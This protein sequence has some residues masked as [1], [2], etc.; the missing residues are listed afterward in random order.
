MRAAIVFDCVF[1]ATSGG[2]ERVYT[3]IADELVA[4]GVTVDYLTRELDA[5]ADAGF[6][7][8]PVWDGEIYDSGGNRTTASALRFALG[9]FR[10]LR[11]HR[12]D[13]DIVIGSTLPALTILAARV[14]LVGSRTFLVADWLEVWPWRKWRSYAGV[15]TGTLGFALQ[16]VS[17]R[18]GD[19]HTVNSLFTAGRL[20]RYRRTPAPLVL[21]LIDLVPPAPAGDTGARGLTRGE[22]PPAEAADPAPPPVVLFVGRHIPDKRATAIPAA[23]VALRRAHPLASAT[24]VGSGP[25]TA[26][27]ERAIEAAGAVGFV[28][29]A[30]RVDDEDL[31]RM[32]R[33]AAVL[34]NPSVREGFG[35]V[36]AEAASHGTPSIVVAGEDNAA[37]ELVQDGVNGFVV[38]SADADELAGGLAAAI[39]GGATLR[40]TT[41]DWFDRERVEHSLSRSVD[42][43]L[44]RYRAAR[45]SD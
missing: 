35:L 39:D 24:I 27:I 18:V 2:G 10:H 21:G 22:V 17:A 13:Y 19:L 11:R 9:V 5:P 26:A 40:R 1:P 29:L 38:A 33:R 31:E 41:L 15:V 14:A 32:L 30:G 7:V 25:E 36:V 23:M 42:E 20:G 28:T 4:R 37:A 34:L 6:R 16:V 45:A 43:I 44:V 8:V 3:R 12:G